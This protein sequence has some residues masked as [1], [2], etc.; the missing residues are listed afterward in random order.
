MESNMLRVVAVDAQGTCKIVELIL[1]SSVP[2][3]WKLPKMSSSLCKWNLQNKPTN[4]KNEMINSETRTHKIAEP[5][6][7]LAKKHVLCHQAISH[8]SEPKLKITPNQL[9]KN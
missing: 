5:W 1:P 2:K 4:Q 3:S 6:H 7:K 8:R 9:K